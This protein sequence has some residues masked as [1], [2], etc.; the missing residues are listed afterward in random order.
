MDNKDVPS[1]SASGH[2]LLDA[3]LARLPRSLAGYDWQ[4]P[5][6]MAGPYWVTGPL[7]LA[8]ALDAATRGARAAAPPAAVLPSAWLYP[9]VG[10]ISRERWQ[11]VVA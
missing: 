1:P 5:R 8:H 10:S 4:T 7:V 3:A 11:C 9:E 2:A 6:P